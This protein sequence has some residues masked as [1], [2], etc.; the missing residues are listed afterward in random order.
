MSFGELMA[1][2]MSQNKLTLY[3]LARKTGHNHATLSR[4]RSG[5]RNPSPKMV[6]TL[7]PHLCA[8][9]REDLELFS[10]AGFLPRPLKSVELDVLAALFI[11]EEASWW[12]NER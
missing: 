12:V 7:A 10:S 1:L 3:K 2:R 5:E 4:L 11:A 9:R 8:S 6:A